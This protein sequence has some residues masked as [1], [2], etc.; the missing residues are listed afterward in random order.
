MERDRQREGAETQTRDK[1]KSGVDIGWSIKCRLE[2]E[3]EAE[4]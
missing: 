3:V 4:D 1:T 2:Y